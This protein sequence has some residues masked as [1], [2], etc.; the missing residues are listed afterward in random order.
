MW[1]T[2]H[3]FPFH[4]HSMMGTSPI[5]KRTLTLVHY[6][7]RFNRLEMRQ[8]GNRSVKRREGRVGGK[9]Q[10]E[11]KRE[12]LRRRDRKRGRNQKEER[13]QVKGRLMCTVEGR[14]TGYPR[15]LWEFR[16]CFNILANTKR[17]QWRLFRA[18]DVIVTLYDVIEPICG[19]QRKQF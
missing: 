12:G 6:R 4:P 19:P 18:S 10:R 1:K 16:N 14:G 5:V 7:L 15:W 2:L 13:K 17:I 8:K 9:S 3:P 11:H